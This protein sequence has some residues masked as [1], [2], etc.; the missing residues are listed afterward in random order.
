MKNMR[1][2][3]AALCAV[4]LL[5][6]FAIPAYASGESWESVEPVTERVEAAVET[7]LVS[8]VEPATETAD[9]VTVEPE[10]VVSAVVTASDA[11]TVTGSA[12]ALSAET[13]VPSSDE[14]AAEVDGGTTGG[15]DWEDQDSEVNT[16]TPEGQG[17]VL[18][19]ATDDEGK[20]FFTI[21][22]A[23]ESVFY[24]VI[25]RQKSEEN[26][27]FLNA[28]TV[29]DLLALAEASG[30]DLTTAITPV[31]EPVADAEPEPEPE[32]EPEDQSGGNMGLLLMALTVVAV[33]G[34]A[35]WY[36]K[37]YRPGQQAAASEEEYE[38]EYD[39]RY[40]GVDDGGAE[41]WEED[42]A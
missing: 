3:A 28:V 41:D 4:V 27:Y 26:V 22:T 18:D 32:P 29:A 21:T 13:A 6:T 2:F 34:G 42:D 40:D 23:D 7:P 11:V 16:L 8:T 31:A 5:C 15:V 37:I 24:L 30:E 1:H 17:T 33:G 38:P 12:A 20:V 19:S 10:P 14:T 39:N 9:A 36:F 25:D 35:G